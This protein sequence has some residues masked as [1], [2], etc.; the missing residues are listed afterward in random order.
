MRGGVSRRRTLPKGIRLNQTGFVPPQ[1]SHRTGSGARAQWDVTSKNSRREQVRDGDGAADPPQRSISTKLPSSTQHRIEPEISVVVCLTK[2]CAES[3]RLLLE[4]DESK[5][6]PSEVDKLLRLYFSIRA[7]WKDQ[8]S[9]PIFVFHPVEFAA[10]V[11]E[12]LASLPG[13]IFVRLKEDACQHNWCKPEAYLWDLPGTYRLVL[14]V[15]CVATGPLPAAVAHPNSTLVTPGIMNH[16]KYFDLHPTILAALGLEL[17]DTSAGQ[18]DAHESRAPCDSRCPST[19]WDD[20]HLDILRRHYL[21]PVPPE[22]PYPNFSSH[23]VLLHNRHAHTVGRVLRKFREECRGAVD[24]SGILGPLLH[25]V[26]EGKWA[27]FPRGFGISVNER[28]MSNRI[29]QEYLRRPEALHSV[30]MIH[31]AHLSI[32]SQ[33]YADHVR[34]ADNMAR[35]WLRNNATPTST[36]DDT[37]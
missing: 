19:L 32:Y 15:A 14:D 27:L 5:S 33:L 6:A 21:S 3:S 36:T 35:A 23:A 13:L 17:P 20:A 11:G 9:L 22:T 4:D 8:L 2:K 7:R 25:Q 16:D 12:L 31:V 24:E 28:H 30:N 10:G 1:S 29:V 34:T 26:T 37:K 18:F